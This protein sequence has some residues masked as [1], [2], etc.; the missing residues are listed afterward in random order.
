MCLQLVNIHDGILQVSRDL[1]KLLRASLTSSSSPPYTEPAAMAAVL[2]PEVV[3]TFD[4]VRVISQG[5]RVVM[6]KEL[7]SLQSDDKVAV[8][9]SEMKKAG[10]R[11]VSAVRTSE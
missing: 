10:E 3:E 6:I 9:V 4:N 5:G 7:R 2:L 8:A 1:G 11:F